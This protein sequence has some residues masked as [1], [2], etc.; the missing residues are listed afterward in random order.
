MRAC[1]AAFFFRGPLILYS[2]VP[3]TQAA[4][5]VYANDRP[6]RQRVMDCGGKEHHSTA[7]RRPGTTQ[8]MRSGCMRRLRATPRWFRMAGLF[9]ILLVW[10][11]FHVAAQETAEDAGKPSWREPFD[12]YLPGPWQSTPYSVRTV[13]RDYGWELGIVL[14]LCAGEAILILALWRQLV[15]RRRAEHRLRESDERMALIVDSAD[16]GMWIWEIPKDNF[17]ASKRARILFGLGPDEALNFDAFLSAVHPEDR[18]FVRLAVDAVL[19]E[20][21]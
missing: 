8:R 6:R 5:C 18:D 17:W 14:L 10:S 7:D 13:W 20:K 9:T 15:S 2:S 16:L 12:I 19:T 1:P 4:R 21:M 3:A 11:G